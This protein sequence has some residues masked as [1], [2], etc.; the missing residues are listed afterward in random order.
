M[1]ITRLFSTDGAARFLLALLSVAL[2]S[3]TACS[4]EKKEPVAP[5]TTEQAAKTEALPEGH[6][7]M[8]SAE[9]KMSMASHSA[10]QTQ[11]EIRLSDEVKNKW[12][13]VEVEITDNSAGRTEAAKLKVGT[14]VKLTQ[15]GYSLGI[16]VFV[17]DYAIVEGRIETRSN[18][19]RNPALLIVLMHN[20]E[21][22]SRGWVFKEYPEFNSYK[23]QR[24]QVVLKGPYVE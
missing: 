11:K 13:E 16:D 24:F 7:P 23:D 2:I 4:K 15:D 5:E 22:L 20:E 12:N 14:L 19:P 3:L 8:D 17:P 6:P 21:T 9:E 10:I 1:E 18:E